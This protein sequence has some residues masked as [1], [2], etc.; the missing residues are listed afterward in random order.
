MGTNGGSSNAWTD[1]ANTVYYF[2]IGN[3]S[4]N[5]GLD[6]FSQFFISPLLNPEYVE[7]EMNAVDSEF[8]KNINNDIWRAQHLFR[9]T[10]N[11]ESPFNMFSTGNLESL[12]KPDI[13][14]Q[15]KAFYEKFYR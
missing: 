6:I 7:K 13:Y 11:P 10:C 15:L 9:Y 5:E 2:N 14:D 4:F 8:Q 1:T 12:K 3:S